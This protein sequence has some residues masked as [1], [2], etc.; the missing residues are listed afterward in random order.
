MALNSVKTLG[1]E[2]TIDTLGERLD[3]HTYSS[4]KTKNQSEPFTWDALS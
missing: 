1:N 4:V 3:R 2:P